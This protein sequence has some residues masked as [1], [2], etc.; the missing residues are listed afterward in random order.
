M[1]LIKFFILSYLNITVFWINGTSHT[2]NIT[3]FSIDACSTTCTITTSTSTITLWP[4]GPLPPEWTS[5]IVKKY[6]IYNC[7]TYQNNICPTLKP[8]GKKWSFSTYLFITFSGV[9][10]YALTACVTEITIHT[11]TCSRLHPPTAYL[12]AC[13]ICRPWCQVWASLKTSRWI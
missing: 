6:A 9:S 2:S 4:L 8:R 12:W 10:S 13:S 7:L 1:L 11:Q 5:L 3:R